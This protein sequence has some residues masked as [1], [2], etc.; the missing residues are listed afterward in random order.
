MH[1][2]DLERLLHAAA[3]PPVPDGHLARVRAAVASA[4]ATSGTRGSRS[5]LWPAAPAA[6]ALLVALVW[7][8]RHPAEP[9]PDTPTVAPVSSTATHTEA[10]EAHDTP[11]A[12]DQPS[13]PRRRAT[14]AR[15]PS[16]L[17]RVQ[18]AARFDDE[19]VFEAVSASSTSS[20]DLSPRLAIVPIVIEPIAVA[21]LPDASTPAIATIDLEPIVID[22]LPLDLPPQEHP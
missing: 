3:R 2:D 7:V 5:V 10:V 22:A 6:A 14:H 18:P 17:A 11:R 4:H 21:P 20:V 8:G 15:R 12:L 19:T 9:T 1:D 16:R 13:A